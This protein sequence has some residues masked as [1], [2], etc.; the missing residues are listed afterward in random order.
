MMSIGRRITTAALCALLTAS[1]LVGCASTAQKADDDAA[2]LEEMY[3]E[4]EQE[5]EFRGKKVPYSRQ[6]AYTLTFGEGDLLPFGQ[7]P[8]AEAGASND[9][10]ANNAEANSA[11][12]NNGEMGSEGGAAQ[13]QGEKAQKRQRRR[14]GDRAGQKAQQ[15]PKPQQPKPQQQQQKVEVTPAHVER[16]LDDGAF[17][18]SPADD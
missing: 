4:L 7:D 10:E 1:P 11:N 15:Q 16:A 18:Y 3:K 6:G 2:K 13:Q 9:A 5:T 12:A 14:P 17:I 8:T